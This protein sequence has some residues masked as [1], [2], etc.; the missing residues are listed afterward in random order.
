MILCKKKYVVTGNRWEVRNP[1]AQ[2]KKVERELGPAES[3]TEPQEAV[4]PSTHPAHS[5]T[6]N[7]QKRIL[8]VVGW[9]LVQTWANRTGL[10]FWTQLQTVV[11]P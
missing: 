7:T 2:H 5:G 9:Q 8:H 1:S 6:M 11:P 4:G 3:H 10:T